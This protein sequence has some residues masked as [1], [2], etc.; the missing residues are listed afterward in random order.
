MPK[1]LTNLSRVSLNEDVLWNLLTKISMI[2]RPFLFDLRELFSGGNLPKAN[3]Y[4]LMTRFVCLSRLCNSLG[5]ISRVS[6]L[7]IQ[8][9]RRRANRLVLCF[10]LQ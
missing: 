10:S 1:E 7:I 6:I 2:V 3:K 9:H 8:E 5:V 4:L